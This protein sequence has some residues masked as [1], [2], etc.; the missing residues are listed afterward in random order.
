MTIFFS[1]LRLAQ[2]VKNILIF[3]PLV[4][5]NRMTD[6][7]LVLK[8]CLAFASF[9]LL[10][11]SVYILNDMADAP[12]DKLH[13]V[14][15]AR[16]LASG[17]LHHTYAWITLVLLLVAGLSLSFYL[18]LACFKLACVYFVVNSLYTFWFK[19]V[20]PFDII[21]VAFF[22]MLRPVYGALAI[23]SPPTHWLILTTFFAAL[24]LVSLK[25]RAEW[26]YSIQNGHRARRNLNDITLKT[27]QSLG[28]MALA[29]TLVCYAIYAGNFP[30]YF[31]LSTILVVSIAYRTVLLSQRSIEKFEFPEKAL[32]R[33][34]YILILVLLWGGYVVGYHLKP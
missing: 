8:S 3:F 14:K 31:V 2:W 6:L 17:H 23:Q 33:D 24:Y 9:C 20:P 34:P 16:P 1:Q 12:L 7:S 25:R 4:F 28:E 18:G 32:L 10:A 15:R 30:H 26:T 27:I 21:A 5:S 11:S 19:R 29:V 13:P 22:Y